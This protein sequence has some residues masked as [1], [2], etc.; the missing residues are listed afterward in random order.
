MRARPASAVDVGTVT[1]GTNTHART[2]TR[3]LRTVVTGEN[4]LFRNFAYVSGTP[5]N[6][7]A[8]V[9]QLHDTYSGFAPDEGE[10]RDSACPASD[11]RGPA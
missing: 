8:F 2:R 4:V 3:S 11:W 7:R 5:R 6:R 9:L 10:L 1:A